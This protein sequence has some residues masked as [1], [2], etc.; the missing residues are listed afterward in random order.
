[1][2]RLHHVSIRTKRLEELLNYYTTFFCAEI[3]HKFIASNGFCYGYMLK[4]N[5]GGIIELIFS[6]L[7]G[8]ET[9]ENAM[10]GLHHFCLALENLDD[11]LAKFPKEFILE[12][13]KIGKT[14]LV[15]QVML[16]DPDK[17]RIELHEIEKS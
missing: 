12:P 8:A 3:V 16:L 17:N 2:I 9:N 1:M 14:D 11:F 7:L 4:F 5:G 6:D 13:I 15:R 10:N